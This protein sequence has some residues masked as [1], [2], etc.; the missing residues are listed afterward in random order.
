M[1]LNITY[2]QMKIIQI[3]IRS[4]ALPVVNNIYIAINLTIIYDNTQYVKHQNTS[5]E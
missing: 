1:S 5:T 2:R 4:K 3:S